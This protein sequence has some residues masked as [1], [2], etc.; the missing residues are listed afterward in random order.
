MEIKRISCTSCGGS[1]FARDEDGNLVC[2]F[3]GAQY[4]SLRDEILCRVCGTLNPSAARRC[5]NCGLILG[6]QCP[7]CAHVNP[8]GAD[9]CEECASPLDAQPP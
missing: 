2:Q 7:V 8:P 1:Q 5:M 6:R 4:Q 9:H 3:C